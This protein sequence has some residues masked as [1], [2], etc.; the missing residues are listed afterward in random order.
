MFARGIVDTLLATTLVAG[1]PLAAVIST[2]SGKKWP[3]SGHA[4]LGN[5]IGVSMIA[6]GVCLLGLAL[7]KRRSPAGQAHGAGTS[8]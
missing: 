7:T 2:L 4:V 5:F 6:A 8:P 3:P 1:A